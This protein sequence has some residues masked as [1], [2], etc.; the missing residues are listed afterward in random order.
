MTSLCPGGINIPMA[1]GW[2]I[3]PEDLIQPEQIAELIDFI[4]KQEKNI[5]FK[6]MLFIPPHE[7]H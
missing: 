5:L 1:A 7:W 3:P 4:L 2:G 6:N